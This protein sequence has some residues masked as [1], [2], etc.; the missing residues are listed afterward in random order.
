M[1]KVY[2]PVR[3]DT[4]D[5]NKLRKIAESLVDTSQKRGNISAVV[6]EAIRE[7]IASHHAAVE[8]A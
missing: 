8:K 6:R 1:S 2:V 4:E 7:F 3:I 5:Y